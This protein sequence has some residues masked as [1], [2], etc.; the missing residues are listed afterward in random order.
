MRSQ[1]THFARIIMMRYLCADSIPGGIADDM[2]PE[3]FDPESL[4]KGIKEEMSEHTNDRS[5]AQEIAM[6]HLTLEPGHY[7]EKDDE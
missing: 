4:E 3:D 1:L 2:S 7:D 5:V 6:D